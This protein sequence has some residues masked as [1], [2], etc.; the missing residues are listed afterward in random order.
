MTLLKLLKSPHINISICHWDNW[1]YVGRSSCP[2]MSGIRLECNSCLKTTKNTLFN[3]RMLLFLNVKCIK[4]HNGEVRLVLTFIVRP[5]SLF[6]CNKMLILPDFTGFWSSVWTGRPQETLKHL[7][8]ISA[9][10]FHMNWH[11][12]DHTFFSVVPISYVE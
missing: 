12:R 4:G 6:F 10:H 1:R 8:T 9:E 5:P 7:Q 2:K 11:S 3:I